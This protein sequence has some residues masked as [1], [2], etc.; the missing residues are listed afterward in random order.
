M[1]SQLILAQLNNLVAHPV[2]KADLL[3]ELGQDALLAKVRA[4]QG[5]FLEYVIMP[6]FL[7]VWHVEAIHEV[8]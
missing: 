7:I 4:H 6:L 3:A 2:G 5:D 1:F 8:E